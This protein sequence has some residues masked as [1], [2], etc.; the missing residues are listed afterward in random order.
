[1]AY[2]QCRVRGQLRRGTLTSQQRPGS[3]GRVGP[4]EP[5]GV[6]QSGKWDDRFPLS[7]ARLILAWHE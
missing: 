6:L 4:G 5:R 7:E 3:A 2:E 1:V